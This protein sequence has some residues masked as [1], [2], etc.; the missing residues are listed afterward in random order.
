MIH[1]NG[2]YVYRRRFEPRHFLIKN[3]DVIAITYEH[4]Q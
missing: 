3:D 4:A 1:D 2:S